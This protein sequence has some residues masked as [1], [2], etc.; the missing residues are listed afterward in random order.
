MTD[1]DAVVVTDREE[2]GAAVGIRRSVFVEEQDVDEDLEFDDGDDEARHFVARVDGDPAGTARV[3][4]I[5]AETAKIERVAVLPEYRGDGVGSET[6]AAAHDYAREQGRSR[7]VL[8]AQARVAEFYESLGYE[9][10]G[11]VEDPTG[12]PHVEMET[13]L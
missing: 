9:E 8:H 3:R 6:M 1:P 7:A 13:R 4:L 10:L 2:P 12:I 5:D 11:P